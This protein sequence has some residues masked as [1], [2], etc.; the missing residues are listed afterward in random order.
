MKRTFLLLLA[1]CLSL[2]AADNFTTG[3]GWLDFPGGQGPG[4]GKTVVL[5]AGDEEYRSEESMP[6]LARI[7]AER[8][9]F[10]CAVLFSHDNGVI[11][12]NNQTSLGNPDALDK[13]DAIVIGLRFRKYPDAVM[14]KFDAAVKR[15]VGFVGVRTSTHCFLGLQG[16][17]ASYNKFGK[18][19]LGETWI[20]HWGNH[21]SEATRG[22]IEAGSESHP[23]L[24]GVGVIFGD[25]DVYEAYPP[26][27]AKILL[28]GLVLAGMK[29]DDALSQR[30]KKRSTDKMEQGV[31]EP[32]MA[33]A[34]V[35]EVPN[36][37]GTTNRTL[38]TTMA[39]ASD[40]RDE[41]LR[42]LLVNGVFWGLKLDVPKKADVTPMVEW[43][44][45]KYS[46]NL[47]RHNLEAKDF[48]GVL[49]PV[50]PNAKPQAK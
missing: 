30:K 1:S 21:K 48:V 26:A 41:S 28:R 36:A 49:P 19:V 29:S 13:A 35:R 25:T 17:Y 7:L 27:D 42:R 32:A 39:S 44:P 16:T 5:L 34:W 43:N 24:N 31:N 18:N 4:A 6:M 8:F 38:C 33:V 47:Y 40:L 15:G 3:P 14:A 11:N 22:V 46:F 45:S 2:V 20:S 12:P 37:A 50:D 9:G 10:H 23:V